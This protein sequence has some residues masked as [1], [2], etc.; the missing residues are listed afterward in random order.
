[1]VPDAAHRTGWV[2][3]RASSFR[4]RELGATVISGAPIDGVVDLGLPGKRHTLAPGFHAD[5]HPR[6]TRAILACR[7]GPGVGYQAPPGSSPETRVRSSADCPQPAGGRA[8]KLDR[9]KR[10]GKRP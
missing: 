9:E 5:P 1:M 3:G 6:V 2:E 10:H 8:R 7:P 4:G